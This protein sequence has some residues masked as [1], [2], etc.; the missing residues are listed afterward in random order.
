MQL[1][2]LH[3]GTLDSGERWG[4][5]RLDG[6]AFPIAAGP[7]VV[8]GEPFR[9]GLSGISIR[10]PVQATPKQRCNEHRSRQLC[11]AYTSSLK[12]A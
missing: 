9:T 3:D 7:I 11:Y 2:R 5:I 1:R 10:A 12:G 6:Q 8:Q 4:Y